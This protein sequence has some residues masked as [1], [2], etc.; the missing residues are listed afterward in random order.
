MQ[1]HYTII[2]TCIKPRIK[3][4]YDFKTFALSIFEWP[5]KTGFTVHGIVICSDS[6]AASHMKFTQSKSYAYPDP[7]IKAKLFN[8][9]L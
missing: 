8:V 6:D 1:N 2:L 4:P 9:K 3:L 7:C 5:V